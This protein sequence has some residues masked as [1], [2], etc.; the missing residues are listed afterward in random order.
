MKCKEE[1]KQENKK[2]SCPSCSSINVIKRGYRHTQ[3][4]GKIQRFSCKDCRFRFVID[5]GFFRMRNTPQK[6]SQSIDLFYRGVSTRKAQEHLAIFHPHNASNVSIYKWV[7]KYSKMI[8]KFTNKLKV[9]V[10]GEV[11]VDEM[12]CHRRISHKAKRGIDKNWFID[13]IDPETKFL[14]SGE[15]SKTRGKRDIKAVVSKIKERTENQIQMVTTDGLLTYPKVIKSVWG[16]N[17]KLKRC[18]VFHNK[19]NASKGEGFNHPIERLHNSVRARTK[20]MRGFHGSINSA[21]AILKG[22]EIYYNFI[23]K[24]QAIKKCPYEL[25]IPELTETLKDSKNKW[26]GLI[27]LTKEAD[28]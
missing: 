10:G 22:Y 1:N 7:V 21:N 17:K 18:N 8:S 27:Q 2:L 3:N 19:V 12:E 14:I 5:D 9:T 28:L 16:Y 13:S 15:Y 6:I 11:Q 25:A 23:T 4:R 24:H 20:V 26:L